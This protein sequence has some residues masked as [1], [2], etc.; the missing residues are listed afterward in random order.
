MIFGKEV[1]PVVVTPLLVILAVS[2]VELPTFVASGD[3]KDATRST[4]VHTG[5]P[6]DQT[7]LPVVASMTHDHGKLPLYP[8]GPEIGIVYDPPGKVADPVFPVYEHAVPDCAA[9]SVPLQASQGA[10]H[11]LPS[12]RVLDVCEPVPQQDEPL[13]TVNVSETVDELAPELVHMKLTVQLP[14]VNVIFF[15]PELVVKSQRELLEL[16]VGQL[17]TV[18]VVDHTRVFVTPGH[19]LRAFAKLICKKRDKDT[20]SNVEIFVIYF[21]HLSVASEHRKKHINILLSVYN[22]STI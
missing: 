11:L 8:V 7:E 4:Y 12:H 16:C 3:T 17:V 14:D 9:V 20:T 2:K 13:T 1:A 15:E 21:I 19:T 5:V 22:L 6:G 10:T 18:P